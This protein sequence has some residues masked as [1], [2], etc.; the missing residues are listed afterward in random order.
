MSRLLRVVIV[1]IIAGTILTFYQ[2]VMK[3]QRSR[4]GAIRA[5]EAIKSGGPS[6]NEYVPV[7]PPAP[8]VR[9]R[10]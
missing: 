8:H 7:R 1:V 2:Q 6:R 9:Q 10:P 5:V 3:E 4:A